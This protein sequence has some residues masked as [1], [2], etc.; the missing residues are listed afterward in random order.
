MPSRLEESGRDKLVSEPRIIGLTCT[1]LTSSKVPRMGAETSV[2]YLY[3]L[4]DA[5]RNTLYVV[6]FHAVAHLFSFIKYHLFQYFVGMVRRRRATG[7]ND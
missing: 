2:T 6:T 1:E 5:S 7:D 3:G 4:Q